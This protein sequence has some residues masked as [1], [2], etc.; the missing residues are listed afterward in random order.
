M[1]DLWVYLSDYLIYVIILVAVIVSIVLL[2]NNLPLSYTMFE[3]AWIGKLAYISVTE[4]MNYN[5]I[6]T[7]KGTI[8]VPIQRQINKKNEELW[9]RY[10][11]EQDS[12]IQY[13]IKN[14]LI[15]SGYKTTNSKTNAIAYS[16]RT[17]FEEKRD[18]NARAITEQGITPHE[19]F[20]LKKS[21][22]GDKVGVYI[23]YNATK[24]K[25]YVGQAKR[26]FFRVNQHFTGHGNGDVYSDYKLGDKFTIVLLSLQDSG[27]YDLDKL[28]KDMIK[29][30]HAYTEGYNRTAGNS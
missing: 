6:Y 28:E 23:I 11:A 10:I 21:V 15:T 14:N 22:S 7:K 4:G 20:E 5:Q 19:F 17:Y 18:Y 24:N 16:I 30:Y 2:Y 1:G 8:R 27:Y 13:L 29:K 3:K 12:I 9:Q 26:L 25:H